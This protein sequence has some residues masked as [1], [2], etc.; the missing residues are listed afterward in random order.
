VQDQPTGALV[1]EISAIVDQELDANR[2]IDGLQPQDTAAC[3][4]TAKKRL[5]GERGAVETPETPAVKQDS[6]GRVV[7]RLERQNL[8]TAAGIDGTTADGPVEHTIVAIS[9]VPI[10]SSSPIP[11]KARCESFYL[12][13]VV[14]EV[15]NTLFKVL[16]DRFKSESKTFCTT[17]RLPDKGA[18][19]DVE[20]TSDAKPIILK[21]VKTAAVFHN[22]LAV[23]HSPDKSPLVNSADEWIE[24]F[25]LATVWLFFRIRDRAIKELQ[26]HVDALSPIDRIYFAKEGRFGVSAWFIDGLN[27]LVQ[28]SSPLT[29]EECERL[30][31]HWVREI[32]M[33]RERCWSL[34]HRKP[35][36]I[37]LVAHSAQGDSCEHADHVISLRWMFRTE[38]REIAVDSSDT[39]LRGV[40]GLSGAAKKKKK[41]SKK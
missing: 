28:R 8:D 32:F 26:P 19:S 1:D 17:Y 30:G 15:E 22:F 6:V 34:H 3:D 18:E 38:I 23:L 36:P 10:E 29:R 35:A 14:F 11:T 33:E 41:C 37:P 5:V 7:Q 4:L 9:P 25:R 21:E 24:I 27:E 20:G 13:T 39:L 40:L 2:D 12:D 31:L 16:Q